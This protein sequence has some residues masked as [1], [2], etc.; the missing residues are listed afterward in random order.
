MTTKSESWKKKKHATPEYRS[1]IETIERARNDKC[2]NCDAFVSESDK[3]CW[4]CKK[5]LGDD[6]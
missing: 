2:P 3:V 5:E 6:K 4:V 1:G